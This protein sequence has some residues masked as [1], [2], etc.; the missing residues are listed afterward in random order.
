MWERY[1]R[2]TAQRRSEEDYFP[3]QVFSRAAEWIEHNHTLRDFFLLIDCFDP[4]EPFDP[5][6]E[7]V[8]LYNPGYSGE[9]LLWPR[10]GRPQAHEHTPEEAAAPHFCG[11]IQTRR[12]SSG[13]KATSASRRKPSRTSAVIGGGSCAPRCAAARKR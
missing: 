2:N 8:D 5:P 12:S 7:Y 6:Q 1:A 10:Y 4:Q 13:A 11:F 3:A 9:A